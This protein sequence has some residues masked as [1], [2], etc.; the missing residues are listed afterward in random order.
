M[1]IMMIVARLNVGGVARNVIQMADALQAVDDVDV[2]L[3]NGHIGADEGDMQYLA[4]GAQFEQV[5][6]PSLGRALSP[7]NDLKTI[8]QLWRL[9]LIHK[10]DVVHTHTAKAGFVGRLAAWLARIPT[11]V[12]T[13]HGHVFHGYFSPRKTQIF[14]WLERFSAQISTGIITLSEALKRDLV[15]IYRV[16]NASKLTIIPLGLNLQPLATMPR[17]Q[18]TFRQALGFAPDVP[19]IAVVGRLVPI[20]NHELFL[21]AAHELHRSN[22]TVR[23]VIV[24][25]GE[26]RQAIEEQIT[27]LGLNDVVTITGWVQDVQTVISDVDL[28]TI[29]SHNEGTPVSLLEA[30]AH[31]VPVVSTDVGGVRDLLSPELTSWIVPLDDPQL[32]AKT[33]QSALSQQG[34]L[35][36]IQKHVLNTYDIQATVKQHLHLYQKKVS[37]KR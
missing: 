5:V 26:R 27:V 12:H 37:G 19:I 1:K 28:V 23:F 4:N 6:L 8:W 25:D 18:G 32:L 24:G 17:R 29:T 21:H 33:W 22:P 16:T 11:R 30:L 34:D 15:D 20:K 35:S 3:V 14:L 36:S 31:G 10:P 2:I 9:M 13:F 7:I